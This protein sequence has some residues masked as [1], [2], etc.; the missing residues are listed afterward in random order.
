MLVPAHR[1]GVSPPDLG[2]PLMETLGRACLHAALVEAGA[3]RGISHGD[4]GQ[5][6][7]PGTLVEAEARR[8]RVICTQSCHH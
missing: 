1:N 4:P 2:E 3:R 7:P 5:S 8:D 6:L